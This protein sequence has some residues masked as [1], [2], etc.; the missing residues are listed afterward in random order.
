MDTFKP[1]FYWENFV[2]PSLRLVSLE[3]VTSARDVAAE[4]SV[5]LHVS[6]SILM[7]INK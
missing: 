5:N 6:F 1:C 3:A 4:S 7:F 2:S